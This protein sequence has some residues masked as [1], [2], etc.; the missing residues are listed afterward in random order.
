MSSKESALTIMAKMALSDGEI[1]PEERAMLR[2]MVDADAS[3][4]QLL[5]KAKT[6]TL[7]E[8]IGQIDKYADRFF[9]A[10]RAYA[11]AMADQVFDARE[12]ALYKTLVDKLE[13]TEDDRALIERSEKAASDNQN[14]EPRVM[15][16]YEQSSFKAAEA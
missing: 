14:P 7:D 4:D 12:E 3:V 2:D 8:M 16:L 1:A 10:L 6:Q 15:E 13:I 5:E 9:I 11:M